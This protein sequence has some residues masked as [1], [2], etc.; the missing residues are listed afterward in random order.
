ML[1]E[2]SIWGTFSDHRPDGKRWSKGTDDRAHL[3]C[4]EDG[5]TRNG[6]VLQVQGE[7]LMREDPRCG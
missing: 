2:E 6:G 1:Q 5:F 4:R 3:H 7:E